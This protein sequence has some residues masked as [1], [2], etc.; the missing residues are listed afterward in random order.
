MKAESY[1]QAVKTYLDYLVSSRLLSRE[2]LRAYR[3]DLDLYGAFL[4]R[5]G[6]SW[7]GA[8]RQTAR[9]F[10]SDQS[11]SGG[12]AASLNRCLSAVRGFYAYQWRRERIA[13]NPFEGLRGFKKGRDL[14]GIIPVG[15]WDVLVESVQGESF[16][17]RRNRLLLEFLFSTGCRVSEAAGANL[18]DLENG[19]RRLRITGKGGKERYV[20]LGARAQEALAVYLPL[21]RLRLDN[22]DPDAGAALFLNHRGR[23]LGVRGIS[24]I[25]D[26]CCRTAGLREPASPH[27]FRHS[28]AT[29][30]L[31]NGANIREVQEMLGHSSLSTTQIY[32]HLGM[33]SLKQ[34]YRRAHPHGGKGVK[35]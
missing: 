12:A 31:D 22:R 1:S 17:A 28:F 20:F 11:L 19:C 13:A 5:E 25:V 29:A 26:H 4:E 7:E 16:A 10:L 8:D 23:R 14:P 24:L 18:R 33:E 6:L 30:L 2:T 3:R 32:T 34:I 9:N 27:T 35:Q 15:E 21:R